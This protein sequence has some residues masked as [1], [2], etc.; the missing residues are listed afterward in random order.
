MLALGDE[1]S[2]KIKKLIIHIKDLS[3]YETFETLREMCD[4]PTMKKAGIRKFTP[5][6]KF[7]ADKK[8][9]A[10]I[11]QFAEKNPEEFQILS[12][13]T[14]QYHQL[15]EKTKMEDLY[16][17]KGNKIPTIILRLLVLLCALPIFLY[18]SINNIIPA[19]IPKL[20]TNKLK[21]RQFESSVVFGM[22]MF[23]FP[24]FYVIQTI[25]IQLIF[26]HWWISVIYI[27]SLPIM[28]LFSFMYYRYFRKFRFLA[29]FAFNKKNTDFVK[30]AGLREEI[31]NK[32]MQIIDS[33]K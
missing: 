28:G 17:E 32:A 11:E 22:G 12:D 18:G 2:D 9:I 26:H 1:M 5:K 6:N 19:L 13:K 4:V 29:R 16:V 7:E 3:Q 25:I 31:L 15:L 24:S 20:I 14:M 8:V 23:V 33:N 30:L 10:G 27:L 21:D